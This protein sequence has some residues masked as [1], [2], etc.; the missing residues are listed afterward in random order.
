MKIGNKLILMI[1]ILS[2]AGTAALTGTILRLAQ[3]QISTLTNN[4][5]TNLANENALAI[6]VWL[7]VYLDVVRAV[8]QVMSKYE[9]I[10]RAE[11]RPFFNM[12]VRTMVEENSE[13]AAASNVWEPNAL[14][15]LDAEF[16]N[17][18]GTDHTGRFIP[19][20]FR[21]ASG[22]ELEPLV[23]YETPGPGDYYLIPKRT[24]EET[25]DEPYEY[26]VGGQK[27]LMTTVTMPIKNRGRFAGAMNIDLDMAAIQ[28]HV[29]QIK[30]YE[31][32]VAIVYSYGGLVS[33]HFDT[34]RIGKPM[35]ETEQDVA[36]PY[37]DALRDAV[38]KGQP[39]SFTHDVPQ[40]GGGMFFISVPVTVGNTTTPWALMLGIP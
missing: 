4:E 28:R 19:Y 17:T 11:R 16:V 15:G 29:E 36:G 10:D 25:L 33:S 23:D 2:L 26:E 38:Q 13:I 18:P 21:T 6:K 24:G 5:I 14:D 31:G 8:G 39:F 40:L 20:W 35:T 34:G 9:E 3:N 37:L 7:E 27:I 1:V 12:M 32:A 22:V 30:P